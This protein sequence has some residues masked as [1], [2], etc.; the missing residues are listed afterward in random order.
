[1]RRVD[2]AV[3]GAGPAGALA[4]RALVLSGASVVLLDRARFPRDKPCGGG[5]TRRTVRLIPF[6][7]DPV[8]EDSIGRIDFRLGYGPRFHRTAEQPL[9][10]M[11]QRRKLDALLVDLAVNAGVELRTGVKASRVE[12]DGSGVVVRTG[13]G[14]VRA[15]LAIG[16]DGAN[17]ISAAAVG[18]PVRRT[19]GVALEGNI[20]YGVASSDRYCGRIVLELGTV[21]GG[22]G[23]IFPKGDHVNIGVAGW[24]GEGAQLRRHL[25]RLLAAHDFPEDAVVG[26]RGHRLPLRATDAPL[27]GNRVLLVGDAAGLVDPLSGDG[28]YEAAL[29]A[30]EAALCARRYLEGN[31]AALD[32][33]GPTLLA[34]NGALC[35][36]SWE[37]KHAFDRFPRLSFALTRLPFAWPVIQALLRGDLIDPSAASG[38]GRAVPLRMLGLLGRAAGAPGEEYR[39]EAAWARSATRSYSAAIGLPTTSTSRSSGSS[40]L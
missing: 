20:P 17:G 26:L 9:V 3:I 35:G 25:A 23:W 19:Y 2:V 24:K 21:R 32:A 16:A 37:W 31:E 6:A 4:A 11:T 22:Y 40:S 1:V 5:L 36:A 39:R 8:V 27:A 12:P 38:P 10:L 34:H 33:Y 29:S 7:L 28:L 15:A 14:D 18:R 30:R 13:A